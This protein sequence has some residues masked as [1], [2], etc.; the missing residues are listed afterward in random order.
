MSSDFVRYCRRSRRLIRTSMN[1]TEQIIEFWEKTVRESPTRRGYRARCPWRAR[2]DTG[3]GQGRSRDPPRRARGLRPGHLRQAGPPRRADP[4]LQRQQP[5]GPG[6]ATRTR[7]GLRDQDLRYRRNQAGRRRAGLEH[8]RPRAQEQPDLHRQHGEA[9]SVHPGDRQRLRQYLARGKT[10][11]T[12]SSPIFSPARARF[13]QADWAWDEMF[14]FVK[15]AQTPVRN[16]LLSTY[17]TMGAVRH[18]D[19]VAKIRVAPTA[20]SAAQ[21]IH[22]E[23]DLAVGPDVFG[24]ALVDEYGREPSI[25]T[26][27][28]SSART[29]TRCRSTTRPSNGRR[30]CLPS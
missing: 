20:E 30:S 28:S 1:C 12:S 6:R 27:R 14:A 29:S 18:G 3:R 17:W 7:S 22:R 25:S 5:S 24:P 2:K 4:V 11:S 9:L 23:L 8:V 19:Y 26:S 13:E 16:P 21:V 10:G 15:A